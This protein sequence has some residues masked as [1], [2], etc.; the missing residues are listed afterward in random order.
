MENGR[1]KIRICLFGIVLAAVV[2]GIFY[3]YF[4]GSGQPLPVREL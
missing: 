1:R 3:Y 2:V 4:N